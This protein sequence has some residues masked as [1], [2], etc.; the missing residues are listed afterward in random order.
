MYIEEIDG[1]KYLIFTSK[2]KNKEVL[3]KYTELWDEIKN[4][5]ETINGG[6]P[7]KHK[8]RLHEK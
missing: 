3:E 2:D 5:M 8:K 6:E 1:D 4:Q 7:I